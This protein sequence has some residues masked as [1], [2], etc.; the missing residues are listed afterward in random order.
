MSGVVPDVDVL[1]EEFRA[2]AIT[3]KRSLIEYREAGEIPEH[4]ADDIKDRGGLE[5][6]SVFTGG[7]IERVDR[8]GGFAGG[9][10]GQG[11]GIE[12]GDVGRVEFLPAR[13]IVAEHGNGDFGERLRVPVGKA[14]GVEDAFEAFGAG[15]NSGGGE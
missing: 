7:E 8:L 6:D 4:E 14:A 13:G 12:A 10:F 11:F 2:Y 1:A 9:G 3:E 15:V 5:N